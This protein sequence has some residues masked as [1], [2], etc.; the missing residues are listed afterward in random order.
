M[1]LLALAADA[2]KKRG[3]TVLRGS[4]V[5]NMTQLTFTCAKG[6]KFKKTIRAVVSRRGWCDTCR[7]GIPASSEEAKKELEKFGFSLVSK[8]SNVSN[9]VTAKCLVCHQIFSRP[10]RKFVKSS[11]SHNVRTSHGVNLRLKNKVLELGGEILSKGIAR[12]DE[13]HT[14]KCAEGH[15]FKLTGQSVIYRNSWCKECGSVWVTQAKVEQLISARGGV[16]LQPIPLTVTGK[17]KLLI[18]CNLGHEFENDWNHMTGTRKGWCQI[19]T[20]GSKSEELARTTFEQLFGGEFRKRRPRWLKN[21]RGRQMELD[22]YEEPLA[23]AFEYQGRQHF[24]AIGIYGKGQNVKQR[25][26]D[27]AMK[28]RLCDENGVTLIELRWDQK[29]TDFP[30]IIRS[31]LGAKAKSLRVDWSKEISFEAAFIRDDRLEELRSALATRNLDLISEKWVDVSYRYKIRCRNC[32]H[33]FEQSARSYLNSRKVAGCKKCSMASVAELVSGRKLGI[34][35]LEDI[36]NRYEALLISDSYVDKKSKYEWICRQGHKVVRNIESIQ[37]SGYLCIECNAPKTQISDLRKFA[38]SR[39]GRI[40]S[41]EYL[42]VHQQ[43]LWQCANGDTF[44]R[45]WTGIQRAKFFCPACE[46][47]LATRKQMIEYAEKFGGRLISEVPLT[48]KDNA[49]WLCSRNHK[50]TRSFANMKYRGT[51]NCPQCGKD[52][53]FKETKFL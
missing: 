6:H 45:T 43:H 3:G 1:R 53:K 28:R 38:E 9:V 23:L 25:A 14:F 4:V 20:K 7:L 32:G 11:C 5:S 42:G 22:G 51:F 12:L 44:E 31:Q 15:I 48:V 17:T 39:G 2:A 24:E 16:P 36:A 10:Y 18:R 29:Y 19:C 21:S 40:L 30:K 47:K 27:D 33:S 35:K 34:S 8:F 41:P 37:R 26:A 52:K 46:E 13:F 50:F 49:E